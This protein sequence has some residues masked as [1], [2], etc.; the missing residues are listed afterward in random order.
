M[1]R[2]DQTIGMVE[3]HAAIVADIHPAIWPERSTIW[4]AARIRQ[5]RN[6]TIGTDAGHPPSLN[7]NHEKAAVGQGDG[8]F[9]K[10]KARCDIPQITLTQRSDS[11]RMCCA[12]LPIP[13]SGLG[14][15]FG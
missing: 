8:A 12:V 5:R 11:G 14:F 13:R 10:A 9:W 4:P 2:Q 6:H 1:A 7:L 3:C 15:L